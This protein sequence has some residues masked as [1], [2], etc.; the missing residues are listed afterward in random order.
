MFSIVF[1][2]TVSIYTLDF[3]EYPGIIVSSIV[4]VNTLN[5]NN[6]KMYSIA[7]VLLF[8][9]QFAAVAVKTISFGGLSEDLA[10]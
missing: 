4:L 3:F 5:S 1:G 8:I 10:E 7:L 9:V 6:D 2:K